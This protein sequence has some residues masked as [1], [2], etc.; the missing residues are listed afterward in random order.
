[1]RGNINLYINQKQWKGHWHTGSQWPL[2]PT[3][4]WQSWKRAKK[5]K[6]ITGHAMPKQYTSDW[7]RIFTL[8]QSHCDC[9]FFTFLSCTIRYIHINLC[10]LLHYSVLLSKYHWTWNVW[11][12]LQLVDSK[13]MWI[14]VGLVCACVTWLAL[15]HQFPAQVRLKFVCWL[16]A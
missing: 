5:Q 2:Q 15:E 3:L 8:A 9:H 14:S 13:M 6:E 11:A 12:L 7:I 16:V 4:H 1:M 10:I